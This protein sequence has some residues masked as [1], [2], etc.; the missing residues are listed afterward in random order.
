MST[1]GEEDNLLRIDKEGALKTLGLLWDSRMDVLKYKV[2]IDETTKLTKRIVLSKIA[3][4]Y[5][6]LGL[7]GPVVII[8][9]CFMQSMW[10]LKTGWDE[11]LPQ[12]M[13]IDWNQFY[14]F[15]SN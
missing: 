5:D 14:I 2:T 9:K 6:P 8:A 3:Q 7:L 1:K 12:K 11:I 15:V 10:Q 4:I 13:Q